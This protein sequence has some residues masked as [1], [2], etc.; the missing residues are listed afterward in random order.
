MNINKDN[1]FELGSRT[2]NSQTEETH[3]DNT[4]T[5]IL[6]DLLKQQKIELNEQTNYLIVSSNE[7][8]NMINERNPN[9]S[10]KI[11]DFEVEKVIQTSGGGYLSLSSQKEF[12]VLSVNN[13]DIYDF[14]DK[15]SIIYSISEGYPKHV[16]FTPSEN[17]MIL[18]YK[19]NCIVY[20]LKHKK[21]CFNQIVDVPTG[22]NFES[23]PL[24]SS[25]EK[26]FILVKNITTLQKYRLSFKHRTKFIKEMPLPKNVQISSIYSIFDDNLFIN[27]VISKSILIFDSSLFP[28]FTFDFKH[29]N[30][31][32][33]DVKLNKDKTKALVTFTNYFDLT[34][35]SYY[36]LNYIYLIDF[37]MM[38]TKQIETV[39]GPI[40]HF[41]WSPNSEEFVIISGNLPAHIIIYNKYGEAKIVLGILYRNFAEWSPDSNC[42]L[43]AGFGNIDTNIDVRNCNTLKL[44]G[45]TK[46][47]HATHFEWSKDNESYLTAI[48]YNKLKVDNGFKIVNSDG[49]ILVNMDMTDKPLHEIFFS[50]R[51]KVIR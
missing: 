15:S 8:V 41:T 13:N 51:S 9:I 37:K 33:A 40:H 11:C 46:S 16:F 36:G 25:N 29:I 35:K 39:K 43:V 4:K 38:K 2:Q 42:I 31:H 49:T 6:L 24:L 45:S 14:N 7:G 19:D 47:N 17:Y 34:G 26:E 3:E 48:T 12:H 20:N 21:E 44:I 23:N 22:V 5:A 27:S 28:I 50:K 10:Q 30:Y 18:T 32:E 1:I